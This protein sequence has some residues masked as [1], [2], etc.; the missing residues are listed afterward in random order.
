ML[1]DGTMKDYMRLSPAQAIDRAKALID[2][3]KAVKGTFV[4]LWHNQSVNGRED[5]SG[6]R[7]VYEEIVRY[8]A[9]P[10]HETVQPS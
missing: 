7:E 1:M 10:K 3:V 8:A 6:W 9:I 5:W 4:T 2:E